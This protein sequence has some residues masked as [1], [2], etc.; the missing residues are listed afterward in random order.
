[1]PPRVELKHLDF[2]KEYDLTSFSLAI[3]ANKFYAEMRESKSDK[4]V[5]KLY[6]QSNET[7]NEWYK[8]D[9]QVRKNI[10]ENNIDSEGKLRNIYFDSVYQDKCFTLFL[11]SIAGI[12]IMMNPNDPLSSHFPS[13]NRSIQMGNDL[14]INQINSNYNE[15]LRVYR[16]LRSIR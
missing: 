8:F 3:V 7:Q 5:I 12:F 14:K 6:R 15:A 11:M 13:I 1:V 4:F 9:S 2:L 10:V 16:E